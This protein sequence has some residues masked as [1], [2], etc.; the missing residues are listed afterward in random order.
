MARGGKGR[1]ST[2]GFV[3]QCAGLDRVARAISQQRIWAQLVRCGPMVGGIELVVGDYRLCEPARLSDRE[4]SGL[5][6]R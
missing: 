3:S 2:V 1:F 5:R 6:S 4:V